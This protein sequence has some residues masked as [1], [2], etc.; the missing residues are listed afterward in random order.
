M[1]N[2]SMNDQYRETIE[3]AVRL[4]EQG[5]VADAV[6]ALNAVLTV[7][8]DVACDAPITTEEEAPVEA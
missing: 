2:G 1:E 7:T 3:L 5:Q 6:E 4:L 8:E